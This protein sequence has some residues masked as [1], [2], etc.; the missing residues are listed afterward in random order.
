VKEKKVK[1]MA[2]IK[3]EEVDEEI[4]EKVAP[5]RKESSSYVFPPIS[6]LSRDQGKPNTGDIKA[7]ANIIKRTL[8]N[9]GIEVEMDEITV[10]Q[11]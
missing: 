10:D 11:R 9:F 1:K 2:D 3:T 7:N 8:Q 5:R 4:V 6:I